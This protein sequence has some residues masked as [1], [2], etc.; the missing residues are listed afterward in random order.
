MCLY[1]PGLAI[2][3]GQYL[4]A[5]LV[6]VV[7]RAI[8]EQWTVLRRFRQF[9]GLHQALLPVIS[10]EPDAGMYAIPPKEVGQVTSFASSRRCREGQKIVG[11]VCSR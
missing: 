4:L 7:D 10:K 1:P 9:E 11:I 2:V 6:K 5:F 8:G 3:L